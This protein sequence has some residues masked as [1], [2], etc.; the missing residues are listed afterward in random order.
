MWTMPTMSSSC[1]RYTG[2]REW[3]SSRICCERLLQRQV[4]PASPRCRR[5]APSRR[6]RW[7]RAAAARWRSAPLLAVELGLLARRLLRV[8]RFLHQ[9][10]DR[11]AQGVLRLRAR[12]CCRRRSSSVL[13]GCCS[14]ALPGVGHAMPMQDARFG[15][16]H[17]A[18]VA[19]MVVVVAGRCSAPCT[20]RCARWC[21]GRRSCAAASRADDAERQQISGA[22]CS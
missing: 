10:G 13:L 1:S 15:H 18:G 6:R 21:A 19:G 12:A 11:F 17:A 2:R 16:F 22:G 14:C 20:T 5:A 7:S 9:F 3:P 8:G 4:R